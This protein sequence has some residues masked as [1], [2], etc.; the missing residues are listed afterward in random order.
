MKK[1]EMSNF[2]FKYEISQ[3]ERLLLKL[4]IEDRYKAINQNVQRVTSKQLLYQIEVEC[5]KKGKK[6]IS[7]ST[8]RRLTGGVNSNDFTQDVM[9]SLLTY[10]EFNTF[11]DL[12][13][14]MQNCISNQVA[15]RRPLNITSFLWPHTLR[16][17]FDN[18]ALLKL[19]CISNDKFYVLESGIDDINV[20]DKITIY[21]LMIKHGFV[22]HVQRSK[23]HHEYINA[24]IRTLKYVNHC[25][26]NTTDNNNTIVSISFEE[27]SKHTSIAEDNTD[28]HLRDITQ[29]LSNNKIPTATLPANANSLWQ[30]S[31]GSDSRSP[32]FS[33]MSLP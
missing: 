30:C 18:G 3:D 9:T 23:Q 31:A 22:C 16:I 19:K 11:N 2:K 28:N 5:Q 20:D 29:P 12:N 10:L 14:S 32:A 33:S 1:K 25:H 4:F 13:L 15:D 21:Q 17:E 24:K 27:K 8:L 26:I 7:E 6:N